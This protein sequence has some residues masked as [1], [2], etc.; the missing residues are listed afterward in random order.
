V[1]LFVGL[2]VG[3]IATLLSGLNP[4]GYAPVPA[5]PGAVVYGGQSNA[6]GLAVAASM[7]S[8]PSAGS[9][10]SAVQIIERNAALGDPLIWVDDPAVNTARN[11]GPRTLDVAGQPAGTCGPERIAGDVLAA[12]N[13]GWN[14][15]IKQSV[16]G[17]GLQ[18]NLLAPSFPSSGGQFMAQHETYIAT[19]LAARATFLAAYV[20]VQ[21]EQDSGEQPDATNYY[22][23]LVAYFDRLRRRFGDFAIIIVRLSSN[24]A[25]G[26]AVPQVRAAQEK[27][28][29]A[30]PRARIVYVDDLAFRDT[31]HF[32][33]NEYGIIGERIAAAILDVVNGVAAPA[34][35]VWGGAGDRV[36]A[37][38]GAALGPVPLPYH[39]ANGLNGRPDVLLLFVSGI[40]QNNYAA[41]AGWTQIID[42]PQ[43]DSG[44]STNARGQM[45]WKRVTVTNGETPPTI[46]DIASDN[47]KHAICGV[48]R[49]CV[50]TGNP[51]VDTSGGTAVA[52]TSLSWPALDTTG[53]NN[54]LIVQF[55]ASPIA[56]A[57][58]Q[59]SAYANS[60]LTEITEQIDISTTSGL[61]GSIIVITGVK[62]AGGAIGATSG[63]LA[64]SATTAYVG[65]AFRS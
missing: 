45:F 54:C 55:V 35:P 28:V 32:G 31:A 60:D 37:A 25:G 23:N 7:S 40:G 33:D 15:I 12:A 9:T 34:N 5:G 65:A 64:T 26:G 46:A 53:T 44:A 3:L 1:S 6:T 38:S 47:S 16:P 13:A 58:A 52:G 24:Y 11:L 59:G 63:T 17:I 57:T 8:Y 41:P 42:S 14:T 20:F 18:N 2:R 56:L 29:R 30:N 49:G 48:L 10:N 36:V 51:F 4:G 43:H 22:D 21:G 27:F 62:A 39:E 50:A 61:G 19:Q